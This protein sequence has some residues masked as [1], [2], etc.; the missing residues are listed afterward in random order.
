[1]NNYYKRTFG[2]LPKKFTLPLE[3]DD[4]PEV[5]ESSL[6]DDEGTRTYLSMVGQLQWLVSLGRFDIFSAVVTMSRFRLMPR[7]GHVE[8][9]KRMFGYV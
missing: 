6:L 3:K 9:L 4:H 8:R 2:D 7:E 1:M 5:D